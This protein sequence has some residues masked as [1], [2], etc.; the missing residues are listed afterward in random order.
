MCTVLRHS[1]QIF[2]QGHDEVLGFHDKDEAYCD[3]EYCLNNI[4]LFKTNP[5]C[6]RGLSGYFIPNRNVRG[7]IWRGGFLTSHLGT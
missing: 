6:L 3:I 5:T 1:Y 2:I 7:T 4:F